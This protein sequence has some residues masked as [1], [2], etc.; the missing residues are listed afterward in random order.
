MPSPPSNPYIISGGAAGKARLS[1][2]SNV[3]HHSTREALL[4]LGDLAGKKL[5]DMGCGGGHVS[6]LAAQLV[7]AS[8]SVTGVDFDAEIIS[9]NRQQA[10]DA[11]ISNIH[12]EAG[13][14]YD[15]VHENAFD[16]AYA[17]F[18]LSHLAQPDLVL[19]NMARSI[20]KG[21][22]ILV[23]DVHF[24]GHFCYPQNA[25]FNQY[26]EWYAAAA[27]HNA[28]NPEIGPALPGLLRQAGFE[29][30][31]F[32]TIQPSFE[33]GEGKQMAVL[34]LKRIRETL[35]SL[36]VAAEKEIQQ[37]SAA[38]QSFTE[39]EESIISLPRIFRAWGRKK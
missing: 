18:L 37:A 11:G 24:S 3:L 12:F 4:R 35:L 16:V 38:L 27:R 10:A 29:D 25:A 32:E 6:F 36:G 14:A 22:Q 20:K 5:L 28:Q 9:L 19:E 13:S 34:T 23:E 7:G 31:G 21:G 26:L 33:R 15:L 1:V 30:V 17:R 8:G 2:L 39:D